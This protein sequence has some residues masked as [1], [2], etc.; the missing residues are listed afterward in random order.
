MGIQAYVP[1]AFTAGQ[2]N[3]ELFTISGKKVYSVKT[4]SSAGKI[5]IP[6]ARFPEAM[7]VL[8][9]ADNGGKTS[10]TTFVLTK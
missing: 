7:Y 1:D 8:S 10:R 5:T 9:I 3:V 4:G 6:A 2:L